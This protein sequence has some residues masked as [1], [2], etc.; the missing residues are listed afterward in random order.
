M[1]P[2]WSAISFILDESRFLFNVCYSLKVRLR[3]LRNVNKAW[4]EGLRAAECGR[5]LRK[6]APKVKRTLGEEMGQ[7]P[8]FTLSDSSAIVKCISLIVYTKYYH[9][10]NSEGFS[11]S[12]LKV[13]LYF[14]LFWKDS[15]KFV[16]LFLTAKGWCI[17]RTFLTR[18]EV[19]SLAGTILRSSA[20]HSFT[21]PFFFLT[22]ADSGDI[23][24]VIQLLSI[25]D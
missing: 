6:K 14:F 15:L 20:L 21:P 1:S 3:C 8:F 18:Q 23:G 19:R 24:I 10:L 25:P 11:E 12:Y 4:E 13:L 17:T 7:G 22:H 9:E 2:E 16:L 5:V